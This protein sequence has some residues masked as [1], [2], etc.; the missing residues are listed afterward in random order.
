[1]ILRAKY[2]EVQTVYSLQ[3]E[4]RRLKEIE[5]FVTASVWREKI[6]EEWY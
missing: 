4:L 1:M 3:N 5:I 6:S 2:G